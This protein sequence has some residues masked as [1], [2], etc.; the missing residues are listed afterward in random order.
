MYK[1]QDLG[2]I[3]FL[4]NSKIPELPHLNGMTRLLQAGLDILEIIIL[5]VF[6]IFIV[7][8]TLQMFTDKRQTN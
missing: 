1:Q 2:R 4:R 3:D 8:A 6:M 7:Y 5:I